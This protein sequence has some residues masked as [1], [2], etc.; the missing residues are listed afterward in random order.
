MFFVANLWLLAFIICSI[1]F[2]IGLAG[3]I[4]YLVRGRVRERQQ[5][6]IL[7]IVMTCLM[8]GGILISLAHLLSSHVVL[9]FDL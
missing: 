8:L 7:I 2:I 9:Y 5:G 4:I 6:F 1:A 3:I